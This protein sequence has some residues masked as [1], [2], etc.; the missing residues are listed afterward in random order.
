MRIKTTLKRK[1]NLEAA[2]ERWVSIAEYT[3]HQ[4][5]LNADGRSP[6]KTGM[7]Y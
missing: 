6:A 2:A 1:G 7:N 4:D 3:D 5:D